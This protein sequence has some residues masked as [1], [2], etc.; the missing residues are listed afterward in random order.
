MTVIIC[1]LREKKLKKLFQ[2][3]EAAETVDSNM[4]LLK[5]C[6][7]IIEFF[8]FSLVFIDPCIR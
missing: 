6:D 2:L 7:T 1:K 5:L 8:F 4:R 3:K